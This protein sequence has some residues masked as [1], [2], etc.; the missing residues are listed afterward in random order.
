N[1]L[2]RHVIALFQ[3]MLIDIRKMLQDRLFINLFHRQPHMVRSILFH[4]LL[5]CFFDYV[6]GEQF[7]YKAL[8][9]LVQKDRSLSSHRF[10][11][12]EPAS[13]L[14]R[15]Q[16]R[17][18]DLNIV[19]MFQTDSV[20]F[21]YL[22]GIPGK[23]REIGRMLIESSDPAACKDRIIRMDRDAFSALVL[24][25]D[26]RT[27]SIFYYYICHCSIFIDLDIIKSFHLGEELACDLFSCDVLM[28]QDP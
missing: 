4:L 24:C 27:L 22:D 8:L 11:D 18:M 9:V 10:R 20:L 28:E 26:S 12:Q 14:S 3:T 5:Y 15:I 19:K 21:R 1:A 25:Q 13:R 17:R 6:P 7:V 16:C 2:F 23:M